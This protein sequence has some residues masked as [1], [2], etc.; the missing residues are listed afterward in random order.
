VEGS[1]LCRSV[2][3]ARSGNGSSKSRV[4][5][6]PDGNRNLAGCSERKA[7]PLR[8]GRRSYLDDRAWFTRMLSRVLSRPR[9][10]AASRTPSSRRCGVPATAAARGWVSGV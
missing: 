7:A 9:R 6:R 1:V 3:N 10:P 2:L 8:V 4:E 5:P